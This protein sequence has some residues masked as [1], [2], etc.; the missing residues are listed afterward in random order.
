MYANGLCKRPM[1]HA[2]LTIQVGGQHTTIEALVVRELPHKLILGMDWLMKA[3]AILDIPGRMLRFKPSIVRE[4]TAEWSAQL[5]QGLP[6]P[7]KEKGTA[8]LSFA[9]KDAAALPLSIPLCLARD[10]KIP[11]YSETRGWVLPPRRERLNALGFKG[12]TTSWGPTAA[13]AGVVAGRCAL[14]IG[15]EAF[16]LPL[17]NLSAKDI[18]LREGTTVA[19]IVE[20]AH[21]SHLEVHSI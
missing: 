9:V 2:W 6:R 7:I 20:D 16:Y 14:E 10:V 15:P 19:K 8:P 13:K 3:K 1:E 4:T 12:F 21:P 18:I 5:S 11:S 17:T